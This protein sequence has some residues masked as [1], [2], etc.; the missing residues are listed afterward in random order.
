MED[1][2]D[3]VDNIKNDIALQR[4]LSES[5][6]MSGDI[7]NGFDPSGK[8]RIKA[9]DLRFQAL[10]SKDSLFKQEK[11]PMNMRKGIAS[12]RRENDGKRRSE[13]K[14]AGIILERQTLKRKTLGKR[15]R[16]V[17]APAVGKFR[18]GMLTL[19]KRDIVDIQGKKRGPQKK[20]KKR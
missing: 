14:E 3:E 9:L 17:G 8:A 7:S 19:S 4:L 5:H 15:E 1:D 2:K 11:M 12:K 13:A 6:L 10:G 20:G 16:G 18:G